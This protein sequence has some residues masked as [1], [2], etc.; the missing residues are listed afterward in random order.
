MAFGQ[1]DTDVFLSVQ[2]T[3]TCRFTT[4]NFVIESGASRT[5]CGLEWLRNTA[6]GFG[7][8]RCLTPSGKPFMFGNMGKYHS[9]GCLVLAGTVSGINKE[10][11]HVV[12]HLSIW[13]DVIALDAPLLMSKASHKSTH[14]MINFAD[15]SLMINNDLNVPLINTN[16]G[17]ILFQW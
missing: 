2:E 8:P 15:D 6:A 12:E 4:L 1:D 10:G 3:L 14:S 17:H 16:V 9:S 7:L 11:M 5:G 13:T